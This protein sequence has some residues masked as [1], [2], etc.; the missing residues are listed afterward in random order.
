MLGASSLDPLACGPKHIRT[1][2]ARIFCTHITRTVISGADASH[3]RRGSS[4]ASLARSQGRRRP[5]DAG[6]SKCSLFAAS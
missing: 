6:K 5:P 4:D 1:T 2:K 3:P